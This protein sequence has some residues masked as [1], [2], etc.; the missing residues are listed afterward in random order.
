MRELLE[1]VDIPETLLTHYPHQISGGEAQRIMIARALT[2]EP[3]ILVLD[4]P[5]SMLDVSIQA[6]MM[7]L[8]KELQKKLG[9]SYLFISHD[10]DVVKWFC[11][12]IAVMKEGTF[13]EQG[14]AEQIIKNPQ[15]PFTK[16]LLENFRI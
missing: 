3:G 9:L 7:T 14:D 10:M 5:T 2:L 16:E 13:V 11:D 12:E 8:L 1:L 6:Q 15:H 4:E